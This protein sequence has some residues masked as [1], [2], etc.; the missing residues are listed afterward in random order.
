MIYRLLVLLAFLPLSAS[1]QYADFPTPGME[2]GAIYVCNP[3]DCPNYFNY[4]SGFGRDTSLCGFTWINSG[5]GYLRTDQGKYYRYVNCSTQALMYD[6]SKGIGDTVF[7]YDL[8]PLQVL[9]VGTFTLDNGSVRKKMALKGLDFFSTTYTWVDGIGDIENSFWVISDFEGGHSQL[10]CVRDSSGII[11]HNPVWPLD[12]DSLLCP[13]PY[14]SFDY[15]CT[16]QTFQFINLSKYSNHYFWD[17]GD[18]ETSTA[19]NPTHTFLSSGCYKVSLKTKSDCLPQQ[20]EMQRWITVNAPVFWKKALNQPPSGFIKMQFLD[21]Q[22]GWA[23]SS[24]TIW[25]TVD[26]GVSWDSVPYPGPDRNV[27]ELQFKDF[28]HGIVSIRKANASYQDILWTNDGINWSV[29]DINATASFSAIERVSDSAAIVASPYQG[30]Y[31]TKNGGQSWTNTYTINGISFF[32]D[33]VSVGD[34]VYFAGRDIS[35]FPYG[36][37]FGKST[38][39]TNWEV[40]MFPNLNN[41]HIMSFVGAQKGW[42]SNGAGI[43]HTEDGGASWVLQAV[44]SG[45]TFE[46]Q[47]ADALHGWACGHHTGIYGTEDGGVTWTQQDCPRTEEGL[48]ALAAI[49]AEKA[50]VVTKDGLFEYSAVPDTISICTTS[51]LGEPAVKQALAFS[52]QP[53]PASENLTIQWTQTPESGLELALF[54][55][56]GIPVLRWPATRIESVSVAHL[57][58]GFYFIQAV[59]DGK[60]MPGGKKLIISR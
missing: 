1:A 45:Y 47:F 17:F 56:Q 38:D 27:I 51:K 22:K 50:Y 11:Y 40:G 13:V 21:D 4:S 32:E 39:L 42:I 49:A 34:T 35:L 41:G 55:A 8:G 58:A 43:F 10:V 46:L 24:N 28:E 15:N 5:Y 7:T 48:G 53:N 31:V 52:I 14:A 30:V 19:E 60:T 6:F 44:L 20:Y 29:M 57:P 25:K 12:C 59:S 33:F 54:N 23:L 16:D 37:G 3:F 18:G 2:F 36:F 26:G 9:D